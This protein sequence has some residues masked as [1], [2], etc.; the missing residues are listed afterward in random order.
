MIDREVPP[1]GPRTKDEVS[2]A[3]AKDWLAL[4]PIGKRESFAAKI[5]ASEGRTVSKAISGEHLPEA[6]TILNSLLV[7]PAALL[8][9]LMLFGGCFVPVSPEAASDNDTILNMLRAASEYFERMK[10]G[11]RCHRDTLALADLFHPL[12]PAMLAIIMEANQ[13][14]GNA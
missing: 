7:N 10:D 6:Q 13:I 8:N 5:G 4:A 12:V 2:D 11:H 3:L 14:R 1:P 9:T